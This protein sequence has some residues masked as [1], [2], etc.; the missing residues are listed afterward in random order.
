[1]ITTLRIDFH[2]SLPV[3]PTRLIGRESERSAVGGLL[4]RPDVRL[5]TLI[6]PG[7]V[8]KT[9]LALSIA[10]ELTSRF[11]DGAYFVALE[12]IC[13]AD[14]V[15][16]TI[17]RALGLHEV[18]GQP[19]LALLVEALREKR[20]LIV[21]DNLEQ[22]MEAAPDIGQLLSA[23]RFLTVL[24]T[25]RSPLRLRMEREFPLAPL[26]L[27]AT[28]PTDALIEND[29][30]ALFVER[31]QAV[32][33]SFVLTDAM[34]PVI[35]EICRQ[36]DGLPLAIE[37]A[38]A[39]TNVLS[40]QA[41]LARMTNRLQLLTNGAV[42][43]PPRQRSLRDAVAWSHD[44]LNADERRLF[45]RL[46]VFVGGCTLEAI[47]AIMEDEP[48]NAAPVSLDPA[49]V[50]ALVGSLLDKSLLQRVDLAN[51]GERFRLLSTI[52]E[53][54]AER[55]DE[56]GEVA[57][58]R[59]RHLEWY[60]ALAEQAQ[61]EL[62]GPSQAVWLESLEQEHDNFR[63]ALAGSLG[64]LP[65][66][67]VRLASALW[68]FWATRGYLS[69]GYRWLEQLLTD[70]S[71]ISPAL[72]ARASISQGN[73]ALDL[74]EYGEAF[75]CY[76]R[77]MRLFEQLED[78]RGVSDALNGQGLVAWY[79]AENAA[80]RDFHE[81][82]LALRQ[83]IGNR[84]GEANSLT[85]LANAVKDEGN[86]EHAREL[87]Q[88]ALDI[89]EILGDRG[90]AGYSRLNLGDVERRLGHA[91]AARV[92]FTESLEAFR[93]VN[94]TLGMG[95]ALQALGLAS[96]MTHDHQQASRYF[97][98]AIAIR[99]RLGDRRG[100]IECLEG[101]A[102]VAEREG[103][104]QRAVRLF[105]AAEAL[106]EQIDARV[107]D[108]DRTLQGAIISRLRTK[109]GEPAFARDWTEGSRL[110]LTDAAEAAA[111]FANEM[112]IDHA[113]PGGLSDREGEVLR[114]IATGLTNAQV[115]DRL[116]LSRRTVDAHMRRIYDKLDL[117]SRVE[118][119][120]F[121]VEHGIA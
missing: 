39:A 35:A 56:A 37:L 51:G 48:D 73:L 47:A 29:A 74:G 78:L 121:A 85:N 2:P 109:V 103:H 36:L 30:V 41:I 72:L 108:A 17:G 40:P 81:R 58:I 76:D 90:G 15:L 62:T 105:G 19:F 75:A 87:H 25:S 43:L 82:S 44:L 91:D 38:A 18:P 46:S 1:M 115:A 66:P 5:V 98:E 49:Q 88:R 12:Q 114:L 107:P 117:S 86:I 84:Q 55:L 26:E 111:A 83:V 59:R 45:R 27:P 95:Y 104:G 4:Q 61:N 71:D 69:E 33:P 96:V 101:I 116:Y 50:V 80:A 67:G 9:H 63:A 112:S 100:V 97:A 23:C 120:R 77:A 94:D 34:A 92:L 16:P 99:L 8:G 21:L 110:A 89:R 70:V 68:R 31:A 53:Y 28:V 13:D 64:R 79:R 11:P 10:D 24:A 3:P 32:R 6:G 14:L 54:A 7:G 57:D 106:R 20:A 52:Q 119:I 118:A 102:T 93:E 113:L 22:V 42:D 65:E 60:L